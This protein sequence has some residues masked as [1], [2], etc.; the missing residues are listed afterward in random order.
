MDIGT[1]CLSL[2]GTCSYDA[3]PVTSLPKGIR[4]SLPLTDKATR[5]LSTAQ[6]LEARSAK[7]QAPDRQEFM[8][9]VPQQKPEQIYTTQPPDIL[10][11]R[12]QEAQLARSPLGQQYPSSSPFQPE[13]QGIHANSNLGSFSR[14]HINAERFGN[15][16]QASHQQRAKANPAELAQHLQPFMDGAFMDGAPWDAGQ[17]THEYMQQSSIHPQ[18]SLPEHNGSRDQPRLYNLVQ[19]PRSTKPLLNLQIPQVPSE[20]QEQKKRSKKE[21]RDPVKVLT[22]NFISSSGDSVGWSFRT[23]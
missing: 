15:A 4:S 7:P 1:R 23:A 16:E 2:S 18:D 14:I 11:E 10:T 12:L 6:M 22:P 17:P 20:E 9:T 21:H 5:L 3:A 19:E 13:S 8:R